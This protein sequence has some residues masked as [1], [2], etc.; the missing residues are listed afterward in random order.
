MTPAGLMTYRDVAKELRVSV[1]QVMRWAVSG[2]LKRHKFSHK[3]TRFQPTQ[4]SKFKERF[5]T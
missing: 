5:L 4:V 2:Q 1:R 3:V